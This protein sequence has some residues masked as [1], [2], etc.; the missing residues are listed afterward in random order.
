MNGGTAKV[1]QLGILTDV[2]GRRFT[3][4]NNGEIKRIKSPNFMM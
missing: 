4:N 1:K 3:F 2:S